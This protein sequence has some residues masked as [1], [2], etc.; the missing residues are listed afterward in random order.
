[1][2]RLCRR[3]VQVLFSGILVI[4]LVRASEADPKEATSPLGWQS[5]PANDERFHLEGRLDRSDMSG[6]VMIWEGSETAVDFSGA[7]LGLKWGEGTGQNFF[8]ISVDGETEVVGVPAGTETRWLW[9]RPLPAGRHHLVVFKR[10]EAL[11]GHVRFKGLEIEAGQEAWK[12]NLPPRRWRMELYGDSI[13]AGAC[14][15]DGASDQWED[16]RTHNFAVSFANLIA[17]EFNADL[18]CE[19]ISG[20]GVVTGWIDV[21]APQIWNRV[22]PT[23][24]SALI[25]D[26]WQPDVIFVHLGD[27]DADFP[28]SRHE[29]FPQDFTPAYLRLVRTIRAAN[30]KAQLVLLMGGMT[31]GATSQPLLDAW[32]TALSELEAGDDAISHFSFAHWTSNHPR[33]SEHRVLADELIAWLKRQPFMG[34]TK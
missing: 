7:R 19:A 3:L 16:R 21:T 25:D 17:R 9:P 23:R 34:R 31:C 27:N 8:N 10:T 13:A 32:K 26:H 30:P 22:Y 15:E 2:K 29:P 20:I 4:G 24:D 11:A 18:R 12:P 6:P 14:S 1:M 5:V 33:T 28:Q